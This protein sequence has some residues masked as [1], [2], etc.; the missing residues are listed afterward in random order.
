MSNQREMERAGGVTAGDAVG[1]KRGR[2][3]DADE[4]AVSGGAPGCFE[5]EMCG[6]AFTTSGDLVKHMRTHTGETA[7]LRDV[8]QGVHRVRHPD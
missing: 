8:Q 4:E 1:R 6:K 2:V 5:C 7:C 3:D